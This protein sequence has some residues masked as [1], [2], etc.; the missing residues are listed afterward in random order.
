MFITLLL[1]YSL[2]ISFYL[3]RKQRATNRRSE[4]DNI[5]YHITSKPDPS[6]EDI[7]VIAEIAKVRQ[8][9]VPWYER[10]L[11]TLGI[12][13]FF[14]MLIGT[15][16]QTINSAKAEIE[17]SSLR[18][19][20]K[21]LESQRSVWN[22]LIK[23]LSEVIVL[24]QSSTGKLEKSEEEVL[25]QRLGYI[26]ESETSG[27]KNDLEKLKI[28]LALKQYAEASALI[29]NSTLVADEASPETLLFLAEVS[30]VDGAKGR[31]KSL[32][33]KFETEL[34]KQPVEWQLRF[35][36]ISA[37]LSSDPKAYSK[38]VAALKHIE[39]NE[40]EEWLKDKVD[41]LKEQA[42]KRGLS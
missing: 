11:S 31:A 25:Q 32:L 19:E 17:S 22:K 15:S 1:M 4:L 41:E 21:V 13:A 36:V 39:L 3:I 16:V 42:R 37:A 38:E 9:E 2:G 12:I 6:M 10:S 35:F 18:Q 23:G 34:S 7:K 26:E 28:Y 24:K 30:F 40:A 29:D 5:W 8:S 14:S 27:N 20:I 33:K